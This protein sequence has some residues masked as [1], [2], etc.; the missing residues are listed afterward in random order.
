MMQGTVRNWNER[1]FGFIKPD[2]GAGDASAPLTSGQK[3]AIRQNIGAFY[4]IS[5]AP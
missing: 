5:A 2:A 1:G 4:G 3:S